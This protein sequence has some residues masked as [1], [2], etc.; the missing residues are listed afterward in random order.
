MRLY[1]RMLTA[2][3]GRPLVGDGRNM[4]GVR[5]ADPAFPK[6]I[7]DVP[8]VL[9]TDLV[10]PGKGLSAYNSPAEIPAHVSGEMW[11]VE[12]DLLPPGLSAVQR[13][14]RTAH[15]QIEPAADMTLDEF[16]KLL[17]GTRDLWQ[18]A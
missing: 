16:Q 15:Y 5:P 18:R 2:V 7:R 9:G 8:A 10:R 17:A 12:T 14:G 4:L 11:E 13:G 3:D 1:R 6:K